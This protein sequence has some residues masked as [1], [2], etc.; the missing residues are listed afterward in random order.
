MAI[1]RELQPVYKCG[2]DTQN[3]ATQF[4][5]LCSHRDCSPS[6]CIIAAKDH[7]SIPVNEAQVRKVASGFA[8]QFRTCAIGGA[9]CRMGEA[10]ESILRLA[11]SDPIVSKN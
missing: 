10:R 8:G 7:T 6:H 11:K 1:V 3:E 4:V 9:I 2:L 5:D